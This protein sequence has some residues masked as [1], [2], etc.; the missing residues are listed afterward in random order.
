[1]RWEILSVQDGML[2]QG[3]EHS[4]LLVNPLSLRA[5][6]L[7]EA[8]AGV[9]SGHLG[10]RKTLYHLYRHL[11]WISMRQDMEW[12]KLCH[13]CTPRRDQHDQV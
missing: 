11:C 6:L 9:S 1:M 7:K 4:W 10:R 3:W 12:C 8:H 13:I 2:Q 5:K